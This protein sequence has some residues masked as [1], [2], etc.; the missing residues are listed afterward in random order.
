VLDVNGYP[1]ISYY[2]GLPNYDLKVAHCDDPNCAPGGDEDIQTLDSTGD[3]GRYTSLALDASGNPVIS[4]YD[5]TN[6][7]LKLYTTPVVLLGFG[8]AASSVDEGVDTAGTVT[9]TVINGPAT[10]TYTATVAYGGPAT[11]GGVDYTGP[12]MVT[13]DCAGGCATGT[14]TQDVLTIIDDALVEPDE[15]AI[16]T[17][18]NPTGGAIL[19]TI[20]T[21]T[22]TIV[23]NDAPEPGVGVFDPGLSKIGVLEPGGLGLPGEQI[24][25]TITVIGGGVV[26]ASDVVVTDTFPPGLRIDSVTVSQGTFSVDGQTVT[27][28]IGQLDPGE[29][30][31]LQVVTTVLGGAPAA[32]INTATLTG[33]G[34]TR[35]ASATAEVITTLPGTGYPPEG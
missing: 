24:T 5:D 6:G 33:G 32:I 14:T 18:S 8:G 21:H 16:L 12:A 23:D 3:V 17:L 7:D 10:G 9:L 4:Y 13:F 19:N 29:V 27:F 15:T 30:V 22:V 31:V 11:S 25:W 35:S 28:T 1:V 2:D 20:T 26:G 34:I